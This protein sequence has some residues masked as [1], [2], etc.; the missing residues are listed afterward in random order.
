MQIAWTLR[1]DPSVER[2]RVTIGDTPI[3]LA[4]EEPDFDVD[5]GQTYDPSGV[6]AWQDLFGLRGRRL[7]SSVNGR[8]ERGQRAV[9]PGRRTPCATSP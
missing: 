3:T 8:E 6:Y 9:R 4:G 5:L 7:V 2:V 1:Q